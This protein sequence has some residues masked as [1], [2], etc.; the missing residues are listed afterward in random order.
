LL[1]AA[2]AALLLG[3]LTSAS[4]AQSAPTPV[5]AYAFNEGAG[6]TVADASGTGNA[7]TIG[8][9]AWSSQ[10]K[11]G[12]ALTFDGTN[13]RVTI[14]DAPSL[15][16]TTGMTL[17]AWVFPTAASTLWKDL[18]YKG[19]DNYYLM[20]SS[21]CQGRPAAG[22]I[23]S[24]SY[25]EAYASSNLALNTWTHLATT[26]DGTTLRLYVNGVQVASKAQTGTL[27]TSSNPLT[28]GGDPIW[29]QHFAGRIDEV[30][31]YNSALSAAQIQADMNT[32]IP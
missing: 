2:V 3:L 13:A 11:Y 15:R 25:G 7:G 22:G 16:L 12:N 31:V 6:T 23:F 5:A 30:R 19:N 20:A 1:V 17:E 9:A 24:G 4:L 10:G 8:S 14:P 21:C 18:I 26:Y 28:I 29:G 32:A 27:A